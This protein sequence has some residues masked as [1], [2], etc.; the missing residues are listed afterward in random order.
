MRTRHQ[1]LAAALFALALS[2]CDKRPA[3]VEAV[4]DKPA[5]A[6]QSPSLPSGAGTSVPP[7]ASVAMPPAAPAGPAAAAGR[8]NKAMTAAE[9][10]GAMPLP[11]QNNDHSAPAA[12]P[13]APA[14]P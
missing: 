5:S 1:M 3:Q 13:K 2:A 6:A 11:G 9:E 14:K 12:T 7:A 10:S 8:S 4:P